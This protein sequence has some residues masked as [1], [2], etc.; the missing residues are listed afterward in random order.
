VNAD[1]TGEYAV[2]SI[3]PPV[4][5]VQHIVSVSITADLVLGGLI[6]FNV[7]GTP[8]TYAA[9][10]A[11]LKGDVAIAIA[12]Q[13]TSDANGTTA[14]ANGADV[15]ITATTA[16]EAIIVDSLTGSI[17]AVTEV[18]AF[19]P[20]ESYEL[21]FDAVTDFA[22]IANANGPIYLKDSAIN[23]LIEFPVD[24]TYDANGV[25]VTQAGTVK[26]GDQLKPGAIFIPNQ[27]TYAINETSI[28]VDAG[29]K[30]KFIAKSSGSLMNNIEVA[31]AREADFASGKSQVFEGLYLNDFFETKPLDSKSEIAIIVRQDT[32]ITGS[33]IVSTIPGSKDYRNKSNYIEDIIN[34]Y[35]SLLYVKDNTGTTTLPQSRIFLSVAIDNSVVSNQLPLK[36]S[37]GTDGSVNKGD[38]ELAYGS[39][40]NNTIFGKSANTDSSSI[41][42]AA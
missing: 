24:A 25:I 18:Q 12:S 35:D 26:T 23:A 41:S 22:T 14:V 30:L 17:S 11:Q 28:P 32:K 42:Y 4:Q 1:I 27:E 13:V 2:Q 33:Y 5:A 21:V 36:T 15:V 10:S 29:T 6:T 16:G 31:I 9:P 37:N 7:N 20:G 34:K 19:V 39:V 3:L 40:A 8:V 38:I